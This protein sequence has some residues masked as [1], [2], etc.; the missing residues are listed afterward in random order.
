[1]KPFHKLAF[2]DFSPA[3]PLYP[4]TPCTLV[5]I[6]A[7]FKSRG[8]RAFPNYLSAA[9]T[10]HIEAGFEWSQL[11]SHTGAWV[12]RIVLRGIGPARQSCS[13]QYAQL[14]ALARPH[15][16]LVAGGPHSPFHFAMLACIFLLREVEISNS[17][18]SA[19]CLNLETMELTWHLPSSK[20]D[21]LALGTRRTWGCLCDVS[22]YGCPFHLA[23][24]HFSWLM[25]SGLP[26]PGSDGPLFPTIDGTVASKSAV[27]A[28]FEAIGALLGQPFVGQTVLRLFLCH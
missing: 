3:V 2:K 5:H 22:G 26:T 16:P 23:Q 27:V 12:T 6:V 19:W 21:H 9:T 10:A 14:C 28:T 7:L 1:M 25:A 18:R 15:D 17:M 4:V 8:Y 13:F 24:E 20:S 11:L